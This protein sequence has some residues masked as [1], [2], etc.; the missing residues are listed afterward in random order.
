MAAAVSSSVVT[1]DAC[2][3][4]RA[5]S[6]LS[7]SDE[8]ADAISTEPSTVASAVKIF[9]FIAGNLPGGYIFRSYKGRFSNHR[10]SAAD[11]LC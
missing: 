2:G 6:S 7:L 3:A 4:G 5:G 8:H 1:G 11:S 9:V 10:Q